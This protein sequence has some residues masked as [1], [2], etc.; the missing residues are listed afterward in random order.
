MRPESLMMSFGYRPEWSEG[1]VKPPIFQTSTFAFR[2]AEEGKEF[3]SYAYGLAER[4]PARPMG[5]IYSRLNNPD[6][7]ILEHRLNLWD[8]AEESAVFASGMAAISTSLLALVPLGGS[9]AFSRPV[10]GGTDYLMETLLPERGIRTQEFP[11]GSDPEVIERVCQDLEAAGAPCRVIFIETPANPTMKLTDIAGIAEVA[12]GRGALCAVDN[13]LLGPLYQ[14]PILHGA[15]LVLYSATKYLGGHS[16]VVAGVALGSAELMGR[17]KLYRTILGTML[18]PHSSWL[19]LRSLETA[20]LRITC[21]RKNAEE[22]VR[23]LSVHP[24]ISRIY[25]PGHDLDASQQLIFDRQCTGP[26]GM[27]AFELCVP[28]EAEAF[29]FMNSLRL[30]KLAVS[31]GGTESLCEHPASMTHSDV[32]PEEQAAIGISPGLI[33]LS[34]GIEHPDD[35]IADIAYALEQVEA[36]ETSEPTV[37][38]RREVD[39]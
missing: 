18:D 36:L 33:R 14:K 21:S 2:S 27:L 19:L 17:I 30:V 35:L 24:K 6:L 4:D 26:G 7:E 39:R 3:F 28:G 25:F 11:A 38:L 15:D 22:L 20:K 1:A 34:V 9:V 12:H 16:D 29:H 13:T 37:A 32:P 10:Y 5:L 8:E 23:W 31:L